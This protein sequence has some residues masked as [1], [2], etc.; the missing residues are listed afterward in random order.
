MESGWEKHSATTWR[1]TKHV[2]TEEFRVKFSTRGHQ[3][4]RQRELLLGYRLMRRATS[5]IHTSEIKKISI[6]V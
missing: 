4:F 6:F 1:T 5:L 2:Q 3:P